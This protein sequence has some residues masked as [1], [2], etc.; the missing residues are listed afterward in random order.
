VLKIKERNVEDR[1]SFVVFLVTAAVLSF[2]L[3]T[4]AEHGAIIAQSA[5][6]FRDASIAALAFSSP[7]PLHPWQV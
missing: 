6:P 2:L 7:M 5:E 3:L 1:V 4:A